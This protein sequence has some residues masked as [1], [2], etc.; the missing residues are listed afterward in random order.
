MNM[1][2]KGSIVYIENGGSPLYVG[3]SK[4]NDPEEA[5]VM[6]KYEGGGLDDGYGRGIVYI[7]LEEFEN[8][9]IYPEQI[10]DSESVSDYTTPNEL[11]PESRSD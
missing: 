4:L 1:P 5:E 2:S 3:G 11:R 6:L 8:R 7:S 10:A 9:R